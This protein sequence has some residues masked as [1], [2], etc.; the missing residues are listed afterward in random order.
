MCSFCG[1]ESCRLC[2]CFSFLRVGGMHTSAANCRRLG[3]HYTSLTFSNGLLVGRG[4]AGAIHEE[5]AHAR[6][7]SAERSPPTGPKREG[8]GREAMGDGGPGG[9]TLTQ[10]QNR[11]AAVR[12]P[13]LWCRMYPVDVEPYGLHVCIELYFLFSAVCCTDCLAWPLLRQRSLFADTRVQALFCFFLSLWR[14]RGQS[15]KKGLRADRLFL[16]VF[17][18][19]LFLLAFSALFFPAAFVRERT[20]MG[21][22]LSQKIKYSWR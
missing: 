15:K 16:L 12:K 11:K 2:I 22:Q 10:E 4:R 17:F 7:A 3:P 19:S 21:G 5:V 18:L 20:A 14:L 9:R 1:A 6:E 13:C 8:V